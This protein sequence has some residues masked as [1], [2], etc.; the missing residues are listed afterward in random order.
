VWLEGLDAGVVGL[1]ARFRYLSSG[2]SGKRSAGTRYSRFLLNYD[3]VP[4][5]FKT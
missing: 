3:D 2:G 4:M 1:V 5:A